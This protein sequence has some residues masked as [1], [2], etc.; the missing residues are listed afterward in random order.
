[1]TEEEFRSGLDSIVD[2]LR[3]E[4]Q[5]ELFVDAKQFENRVREVAQDVFGNSTIDFNPSAQ[6]FPDIAIGNFGIEV[7]FTTNDTWRSVANSVL[8]TNR[9]EDVQEVYLVFGKMGG[10]PDVKWDQYARSVMHVRTSHVPRFEVEIGTERSLFTQMGVS[11]D[12][13][14]HAEMHEKMEFIRRYARGR[15]KPGERLWWLEDR[16]GEE[17]SLPIQARLYTKLP[18]D[19]KVKLRAEAVLLCPQVVDSGRSRSKYDDVVLYLLTYH[20]VLCHQ[21]RDLFSAGS[22]ANPNNDDNGGVYIARAIKLI[23]D[24]IRTAANRMDNA[25]FREYWGAEVEPRDRIREWLRRA[26][27]F[28]RDW[29]PSE[30]LFLKD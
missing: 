11:Y 12:D 22:V 27:N 28:A 9:V 1:M 24:E 4:A 10:D 7:K 6:G 20:G 23:E 15:L 3:K 29:R 30:M 21:A 25:L 26:D 5:R 17:H 8:E 19:E 16:P 18:Q 2:Q 14:R 13:F